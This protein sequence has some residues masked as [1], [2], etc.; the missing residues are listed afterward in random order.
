MPQ[1]ITIKKHN[2]SNNFKKNN[3]TNKKRNQ[4]NNI[5]LLLQII[6]S[7]NNGSVFSLKNDIF[8]KGK[9]L[10]IDNKDDNLIFLNSTKEN[11]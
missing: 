11:K 9:S 8:L 3:K 10:Q 1:L 4:N 6:S 2:N 5:N 7:V